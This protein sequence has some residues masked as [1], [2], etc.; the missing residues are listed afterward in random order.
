ML[1][2]KER[3]RER[4]NQRE[5][6]ARK[7]ESVQI[8]RLRD[9]KRISESTHHISWFVWHSFNS[10]HC[11]FWWLLL[12]N[13]RIFE[14]CRADVC[15]IDAWVSMTLTVGVKP[16]IEIYTLNF[17]NFLLPLPMLIVA[18]MRKYTDSYNKH[19]N[20]PRQNHGRMIG[21]LLFFFCYFLLFMVSMHSM[22]VCM[23][24]TSV[25]EPNLEKKSKLNR[26]ST[27]LRMQL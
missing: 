26:Y 21:S 11:W 22:C 1:L 18:M 12:W 17:S 20:F 2:L 24:V 14:L 10:D 8:D 5:N 7:L 27:F 9:E 23:Y 25:R 4:E 6:G 3:K 19:G 15:F 16:R 13:S